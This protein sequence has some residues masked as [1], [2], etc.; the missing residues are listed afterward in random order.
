MLEALLGRGPAQAQMQ[1]GSQT[2]DSLEAFAGFASATPQF[3]D[4][5]LL[6]NI[7]LHRA[8][9]WDHAAGLAVLDGDSSIHKDVVLTTTRV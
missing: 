4:A 7:A 6:E 5:S 1:N 2:L 3:V 9:T 8:G